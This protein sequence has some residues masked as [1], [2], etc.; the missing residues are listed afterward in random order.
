M[1]PEKVIIQNEI[2][3][4]KTYKKTTT[5]EN[6]GLKI[7]LEYIGLFLLVIAAWQWRKEVGFDSFSFIS[8][9]PEVNPTDPENRSND[10]GDAPP[11]KT[12]PLSPDTKST[13]A[14]EEFEVFK[15]NEKLRMILELMRENPNSIT[16]ASIIANKI[17]VS[18]DTAEL[19]LFELL[20]EKLVRK[21]AYPGSRNSVYSLTN[22]LDNL[23]IDHFIRNTLKPEE[24]YGDYRFV[25]LKS[26]FEIDA[27]IK[28]SKAN[29]IIE[30]KFLRKISTDILIKGIQHLLKIEEE[31]NLEPVFL[32]LLIVGSFDS[33]KEIQLEKLKLK[34]NLK[35]Y[36]IDKDKI[37]SHES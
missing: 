13:I 22:S 27:L 30:T 23:A 31:I 34:E 9:Q 14:L 10:D 32:V 28:T 11:D 12:P 25:R 19:Y 4:T 5:T 24:I 21:D 35:I 37:A 20:K 29:Y 16:N 33:I 26:R 3:V 17:G 18:R 15:K 6:D 36:L 2:Q 1:T 7:F 8:K